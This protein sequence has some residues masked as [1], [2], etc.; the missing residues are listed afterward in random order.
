MEF[1]FYVCSF[2]AVVSTFFVIIQKNAVYSLVYLIISLLSIAGVFFSL[3]AFFAGSLEVIIYA[4]AI[5][6]L[7][8]F[9]IMMLNISDKYNL[10]EAHYLKPRFWIGPSILS[11]ILLL[12]MTYAIFFL[13]DKKIDGFLID[14]KIVGINLFG[15]YV[16]L[17]E[18]SSILLLSALVVIF[19]IGTEK[20]VDKNKVL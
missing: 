16:F 14:S 8:V 15:P 6:V 17:V 11:L 2:A 7:F 9:V 3:G 10:E 19:H 1:V 4:G 12:S 20:N 5:I 13:R 18:L